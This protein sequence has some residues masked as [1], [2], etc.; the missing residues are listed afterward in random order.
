MVALPSIFVDLKKKLMR[1]GVEQKGTK[2]SGLLMETETHA[3]CI[4][5]NVTI[6]V[7]LE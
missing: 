6:G 1:S 2:Y 3:L 4:H 7:R 5:R